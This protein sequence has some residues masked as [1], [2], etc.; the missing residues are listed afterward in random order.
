MGDGD[1]G[2]VQAVIDLCGR[3][4]FTVAKK[5]QKPG[6]T[7][8]QLLDD[9]QLADIEKQKSASP[10]FHVKPGLPPFLII[11]GDLDKTVPLEISVRFH[12]ALTN[13]G[14]KSELIIVKGADHNFLPAKGGPPPQPDHKAQMERV[15]AFLKEAMP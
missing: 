6:G 12:E 4:D 11:H 1:G 5:S 7:V 9:P 10:L 3:A 14:V 15:R 2:Q 13:A 8:S